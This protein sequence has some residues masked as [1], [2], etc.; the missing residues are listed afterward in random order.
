MLG[1]ATYQLLT[2][3][4]LVPSNITEEADDDNDQLGWIMAMASDRIKES[5]AL[6][7]K[8]RDEFFTDEGI[9]FED[10]PETDLKAALKASGKVAEQDIPEIAR[11][12][13]KCLSLDPADRPTV[14]ALHTEPWIQKGLACS[15]GYC[16]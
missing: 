8:H 9:F 15:C 14:S 1:C 11:F 7:S 2:G 3:E 12:I 16:G 13:E 4:P 6:K 10:I 5:M